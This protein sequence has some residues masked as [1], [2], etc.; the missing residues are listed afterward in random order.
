[1]DITPRVGVELCGFGP[2]LN[3]HSTRVIEPLFARAM[4]VEQE[5]E[6]WVLMS[7]DLIAFNPKLTGQIR[8]LVGKATGLRDDQIMLHA[9]H[10]HCG[11]CTIPELIGWGDPDDLYLESLP[12]FVAKACV[13]AIN[14]LGVATFH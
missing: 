3:R 1:M 4:A 14:D 8:A 5:G 7:A 9:T 2:Y 6:R 12:R 11:P 13:D 10:T